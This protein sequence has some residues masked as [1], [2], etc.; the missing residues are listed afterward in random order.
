MNY[1][2]VYPAYIFLAMLVI[3]IVEIVVIY[4]AIADDLKNMAKKRA[5]FVSSLQ[6][7]PPK[8][9]VTLLEYKTTNT[10]AAS[11]MRE[12]SRAASVKPSVASVAT[13]EPISK[14]L[15]FKDIHTLDLIFDVPEGHIKDIDFT[16]DDDLIPAVQQSRESKVFADFLSE[17]QK[18]KISNYFFNY[19]GNASF[20]ELVE[21]K[22][23]W[24]SGI[25]KKVLVLTDINPEKKVTFSHFLSFEKSDILDVIDPEIFWGVDV[26][27]SVTTQEALPDVRKDKV[28][29]ICDRYDEI[30]IFE[31]NQ[32]ETRVLTTLG[33]SINTDEQQEIETEAYDQ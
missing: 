5:S 8:S 9:N 27:A 7:L 26:C 30:W 3:F 31:P 19:D 10:A 1:D 24:K 29:E 14:H 6:L 33:L 15:Q 28:K 22:L 17:D 21:K 23:K 16:E 2:S 13:S 25:K 20:L 11:P 12:A 18:N 4:S 32:N